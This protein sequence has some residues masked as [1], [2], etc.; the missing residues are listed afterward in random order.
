MKAH[1]KRV[2]ETLSSV[3]PSIMDAVCAFEQSLRAERRLSENTVR[4]YA[5]TLDRF[6]SFLRANGIA[7]ET[8]RS[9]EPLEARQFRGFLA[10]RREDGAGVAT[11]KLDLS[12]LRTFF[13][14]L[15]QRYAIENDA[16]SVMRGP[17]AKPQLPRP[18]KAA[19][20]DDLINVVLEADKPAWI[21]ARDIAVFL[22]LYGLGLRISEALS[23]TWREVP[24][25]ASLS[26]VGKG[27][28]P[29]L[30]PV[31]P[32]VRQ[33]IDEYTDLCPYAAKK[34]DPLFFSN[35]GKP[36]S[37][38]VVQ[39]DL[40]AYGAIAGLPPSATPHALRHSFATHLLAN[41]GD[42]RS[43]QELLGHK[44]ISATQRYT[45]VDEDAMLA[46]YD[47]AHPRA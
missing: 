38:R 23:L 8:V 24:L 15:N 26:I 9:L 31:L 1:P 27:S 16:I 6:I 46:V 39:R 35:R 5:L 11:L 14:F 17:R 2:K 37:A 29:R 43:V 19:Q 4:N 13:K 40:K 45:K 18:V 12:A 21:R 30:V 34:A 42:L 44:S 3:D 41:G 25:P 36:L 7:A 10:S 33:A 32:A 22:C 28:K 20:I 47:K